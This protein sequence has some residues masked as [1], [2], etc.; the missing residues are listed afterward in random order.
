MGDFNAR[1][2]KRSGAELRVAQFGYGQRNEQGQMLAHFMEK[3]GLFMMN[4][5]FE[6]RPHRKWTWLSPDGSTRN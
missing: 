5:F 2:G 1:L 6:K 4:A 3:E